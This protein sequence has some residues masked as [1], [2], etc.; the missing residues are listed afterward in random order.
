MEMSTEQFQTFLQRVVETINGTVNPRLNTP[1]SV[2]KKSFAETSKKDLERLDSKNF[3]DWKFKLEIAARAVHP[4]NFELLRFWEM[5]TEKIKI[6]D[7]NADD[8]AASA[9]LHC[10]LSSQTSDEA[11]DL[12]KTVEDLNGA[13][14]LRQTARID[15]KTIGK[16]MLLARR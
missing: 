11:F 14:S 3:T 4:G 2:G 16:H 1:G 8:K 5:S 15:P 13:E 9:K 6:D 7:E 10:V 12:V